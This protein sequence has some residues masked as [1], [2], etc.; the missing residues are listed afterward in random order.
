MKRASP[1]NGWLC[2]KRLHRTSR[3]LLFWR[4][5]KTA[6]FDYFLRSAKTLAPSL[7][8]YVVPLPIENATDIERSVEAFAREPNGG[9]VLPPDTTTVVHRDL[10]IKLAARHKLPAIYI[11]R[12]FVA[13][14]GLMSYGIDYIH[15]QAG[16]QLCRSHP[17]G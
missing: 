8:I 7:A 6:A 12:S 3:A 17:Q 4:I 5:R 2:S 1:A 13:A 16:G 9:L 11:D 15:L 10:I 14:G